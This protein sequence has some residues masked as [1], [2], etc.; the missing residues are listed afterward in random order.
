MMAYL[1]SL[2][3][4]S[5]L[6]LLMALL[7]LPG[8]ALGMAVQLVPALI[9]WMRPVRDR[10]RYCIL[11]M[12]LLSIPYGGWLVVL[13]FALL[14]PREPAPWSDDGGWPDGVERPPQLPVPHPPS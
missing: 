5:P 1:V 8:F 10:A 14:A 2:L 11:M 13:L 7:G 3:A 12:S 6:W 4:G 9:A